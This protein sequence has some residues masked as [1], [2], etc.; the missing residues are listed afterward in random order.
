M[1]DYCG[2]SNEL[3]RL[4]KEP[5]DT[6]ILGVYIPDAKTKTRYPAFNSEKTS[7]VLLENGLM[8]MEDVAVTYRKVYSQ[9]H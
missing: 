7:F 3:D 1:Y 9:T 8:R 6:E 2:H 4:A 5:G